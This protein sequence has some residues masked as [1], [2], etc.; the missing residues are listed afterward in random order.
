MVKGQSQTLTVKKRR[1]ISHEMH[2]LLFNVKLFIQN[3][4]K[5]KQC[6]WASII[7]PH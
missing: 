1:V 4:M 3:D 7:I 5:R 6:L 2:N